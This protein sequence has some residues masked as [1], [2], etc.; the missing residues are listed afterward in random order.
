[1]RF[2]ISIFIFILNCPALA[3]FMYSTGTHVPFFNK[4]QVN[5]KGE[6]SKFDLNPYLGLGTQYHL[7]GAHYALPEFGYAYFLTTPSEY[8]K[9]IFFLHYNLGYVFNESLILRY[10]LTTHWYRIK[11]SGGSVNLRNGTGLTNFPSPDR[12]VTTYFTTLNFGA[13]Y[14]FNSKANG[15]RFDFNTMAPKNFF[16]ERIYNYILSFNFYR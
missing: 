1:M 16:N 2:L 10:G 7:S 14:F 12:T 6:T 4:V 11:G 3:S 8:K 5:T 9:E 15:F 13:E